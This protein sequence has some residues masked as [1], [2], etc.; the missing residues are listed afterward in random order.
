MKIEKGCAKTSDQKLN[1]AYADCC[2][3]LREIHNPSLKCGDN[4]PTKSALTTY[5]LVLDPSV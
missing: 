3:G 4:I 2:L 1:M 5:S